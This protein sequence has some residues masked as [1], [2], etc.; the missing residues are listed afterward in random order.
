MQR[1]QRRKGLRAELKQPLGSAQV[2]QPVQTEIT[3]LNARECDRRLRQQ[4]LPAVTGRHDP[5]RLVHIQADV[6]RRRSHRLTR[7]HPHPHPYLAPLPPLGPR[8]RLLAL[9]CRRNPLLRTRE[10][11]EER[12]ALLVDLITV[13]LFEYLP[14]KPPVQVERLPIP[15]RTQPLQ[16]QRRALHIREQQRHRP[17]RLRHH[18]V[19]ISPLRDEVTSWSTSAH[20]VTTLGPRSGAGPDDSP[21]QRPRRRVAAPLGVMPAGPWASS[22]DREHLLHLVHGSARRVRSDLDRRRAQGARL[23]LGS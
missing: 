18:H 17:R 20:D 22:V 21:T 8:K 11:Y 6:L 1:L 5:R 14:Q 15:L 7:M 3:H 2:L 19:T 13:M 12:I 10:R 4:Y 16:Q 9:S 23:Q